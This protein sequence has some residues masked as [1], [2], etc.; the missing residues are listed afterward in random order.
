MRSNYFTQNIHKRKNNFLRF[1]AKIVLITSN[2]ILCG[3][4][5]QFENIPTLLYV[6]KNVDLKFKNIALE[7]VNQLV[8]ISF[9]QQLL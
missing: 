3:V 8:C 9:E 7:E 4:L 2:V 1:C 5:D 6:L